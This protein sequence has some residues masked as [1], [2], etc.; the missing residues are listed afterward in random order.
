MLFQKHSIKSAL[1]LCVVACNLQTTPSCF[2]T[3]L[4]GL[5]I[6]TYICVSLLNRIRVFKSYC[7]GSRME[8][9][10]SGIPDAKSIKD[11]FNKPSSW[12][13]YLY[14]KP[15]TPGISSDMINSVNA[16]FLLLWLLYV[17]GMCIDI[18]VHVILTVFTVLWILSFITNYVWISVW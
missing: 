3:G 15:D 4:Y 14:L 8:R 7:R 5:C 11:T 13:V 9:V 6:Y 12:R 2:S 18:H 1:K 17:R 10:F 16:I